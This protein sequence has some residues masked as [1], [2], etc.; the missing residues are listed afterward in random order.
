MVFN[1]NHVETP[2][3][4]AEP[5]V[6]SHVGG[7]SFA[8]FLH[9]KGEADLAAY[10]ALRM[11]AE[12]MPLF[13]AIDIRARN[14]AAVPRRLFDTR[15]EEFVDEHPLLDLL[16]APNADMSGNELQYAFSSYFDA[17]GNAYMVAT[18]RV[19]KPPLEISVV[20]SQNITFGQGSE[21][22]GML[23]VPANL[24]LTRSTTGGLEQFFAEEVRGQGSQSTIRYYNKARDAELWHVRQFN[25]FRS[26]GRFAGMSR[27]QPIWLEVQQ[28]LSGNISNLSLLKRG[29]KLSLA[30]VNNRGEELTDKQWLRI[31]AEAEKYA[32]AHNAGGTPVL[33]GMDIKEIQA[34]NRDMEFRDLQTDMLARISTIYGIPLAILLDKAMTLDNMKTAGLQ[35]WDN[36]LTPLV[37]TLQSELSRFLLNRYPR[38]EDLELRMN[39]GDIPALRTRVLDNAD[40]QNKLGVNT[41]DE[42]RTSIG[43]EP[44]AKGGDVILVPTSVTPYTGE[45]PLPPAG[46]P[47][48]PAPKKPVGTKFEKILLA[49]KT[50]EGLPRYTPE[51]AA[52]IKL[53]T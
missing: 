19:E 49:L 50:A 53:L 48:L 4:I 40:V 11:Y 25:P 28:Y 34:K 20:P 43:D 8:D 30:W 6:K 1:P 46:E 24:W 16:K 22:F 17:T 7:T 33:D 10:A 52:K 35:L 23:H 44:L 47:K 9:G 29:T 31:Q 13:N 14:Y 42:I 12:A 39:E 18:G 45:D 2:A 51:E 5:E 37:G 27:A 38:T 36:A 26:I 41:V 15:K 32:G 21:R 3:P